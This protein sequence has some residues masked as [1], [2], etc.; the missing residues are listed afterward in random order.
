M[1]KYLARVSLAFSII[2]SGGAFTADFDKGLKAIQAGD[3]KVVL[4]EWIPLAEQG[5]SQAQPN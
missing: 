1:R 2:L 4:G 5:D 3:Y